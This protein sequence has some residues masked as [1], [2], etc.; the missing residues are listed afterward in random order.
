MKIE[1][2]GTRKEIVWEIEKLMNRNREFIFDIFFFSM[3]KSAYLSI[4]YFKQC[5]LRFMKF[6]HHITKLKLQAT[7]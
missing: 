1:R 6:F 4:L 3:R 7:Q 2:E 5:Y